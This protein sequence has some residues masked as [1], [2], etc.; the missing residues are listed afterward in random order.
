MTEYTSDVKTIPYSSEVIF[1]VLS[2][3]RKLDLVKDKLPENKVNNF[4]YDQDSCSLNV[5]PIGNVKFVIVERN[6][7]SSIKLEAQQL[8]FE[9]NL[10]IELKQNSENETNLGLVVNA[11]LNPFLKPMVSKPLQEGLNKMADM[12]ASLPYNELTDK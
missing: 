4:T 2:D 7:H 8:P 1:A 5:S 10:T 9:L 11:N 3:F 12:L 6:P